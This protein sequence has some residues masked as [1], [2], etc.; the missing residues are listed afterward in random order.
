MGDGYE[1]FRKGLTA[2]VQLADLQ[3]GHSDGLGGFVGEDYI[4]VQVADYGA[5]VGFRRLAYER[6]P[7]I[8]A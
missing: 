4:G 5:C 3:F 6:L 2:G 7:T 8:S 1:S